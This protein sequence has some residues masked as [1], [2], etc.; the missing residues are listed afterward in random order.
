MDGK[1]LRLEESCFR[2]SAG[3]LYKEEIASPCLARLAILYRM[4]RNPLQD[5]AQSF[6][7]CC[8]ILYR[9]LRYDNKE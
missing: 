1:I 6:T 8:A 7:G 4:L 2:M 5:A 9:M 3:A